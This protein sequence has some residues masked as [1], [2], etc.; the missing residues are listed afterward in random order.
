[1]VIDSGATSNFVRKEENLPKTGP[2][3]KVVR[4]PDGRCTKA[5]A[6]M[7]LPYPTLNAPARKAH[8]LPALNKNSLLSVPTLA[9]AGYTT[10][11]HP[12]QKGVDVYNGEDVTIQ[13]HTP[14]VLQGCREMSGLWTVKAKYKQEKEQANTVYDLPSIPK[15]I[16]FLHAAAGFPVKDTWLK[17]IK[18]GHYDTWPG[19][20]PEAVAKHCPDAIETQKGHM[21]KQRQ[22]VR[23]TRMHV[24]NNDETRSVPC[25][26]RQDVYIK[27]FNARDTIHTDQTGNLPVTSS[28]GNK[29][30]MVLVNVDGNY[31]DAEPLKDHT[32]ASLIK[33]YQALWSRLTASKVITPKMHV[34]DNEASTAFKTAIK[35]NCDLQLVPP[36]THRR[37]LAERAIQTF[38]CHFI[39]ILPG[40]DEFFPMQLW[41]RLLPQAVLTLNL[42]RRANAKPSISAYEYVNGKFDYNK[43]PLAPMGCAVQIYESPNN[44]HTWAP[45]A[46]DGWYLKTSPEHY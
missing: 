31:I 40:V 33:A 36:D 18:N 20:T 43:M 15:A 3:T 7:E 25:A 14:P 8:V 45:H 28:R 6:T 11:F 27:I 17:A 39:A 24:H 35:A 44:R 16:R 32:E 5:S 41:D 10:I 12:H 22:N 34:L 42:L 2:S 26:K 1:M 30:I 13:A 9:D 19:L 23:S 46:V 37:N 29:L 38:K 21:K 4:M